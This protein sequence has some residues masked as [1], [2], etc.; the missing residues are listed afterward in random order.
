MQNDTTYSLR[1]DSSYVQF[2]PEKWYHHSNDRLTGKKEVKS[3]FFLP[4]VF[5]FFLKLSGWSLVG[6]NIKKLLLLQFAYFIFIRVPFWLW[7]YTLRS[8]LWHCSLV[9]LMTCGSAISR[10]LLLLL[11]VL[12]SQFAKKKKKMGKHISIQ[13]SLFSGALGFDRFLRCVAMW[14]FVTD[15]RNIKTSST[16]AMLKLICRLSIR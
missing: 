2:Y 10:L 7:S 12:C 5:F 16:L 4:K 13:I 6:M 11:Y 15:R 1:I 8:I 3:N 14:Y 9:M